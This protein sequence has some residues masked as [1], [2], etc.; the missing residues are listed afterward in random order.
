M[1]SAV[2]QKSKSWLSIHGN[3]NGAL[4]MA[5][6][7]AEL[8]ADS[9]DPTYYGRSSDRNPLGPVGSDVTVARGGTWQD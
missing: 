5:A 4:D 3:L 7:V 2:P 1:V 9:Y 8:C 6:N